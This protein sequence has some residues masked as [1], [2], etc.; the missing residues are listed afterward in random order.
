MR[1]TFILL[2]LANVAVLILFQMSG[3]RTPH[4]ESAAGHEPFQADKVKIVAAPAPV[5]AVATAEPAAPTE[6]LATPPIAP[7][8]ALAPPAPPAK[9]AQQCVEW[10]NLAEADLDRA[11]QALQ[12]LK[13]ADKAN[14]HKSEKTTGYW[15]YV[16][17]R[18]SLAEAQKKVGEL[19]ARGVADIFILQENTAWRY[20]ISLGVF[21]TE[22]AAANYLAQLREKGVRSAVT[23]PRNKAGDAH[24][25]SLRGLD[26]GAAAQIAK[27]A[28][29][30]ADSDV[31][32]VE[33]R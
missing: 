33:C 7:S 19:K 2:L 27:L 21:S 4:A 31:R 22:A 25:V 8:K 26:A 10:N 24:A 1:L 9:P 12:G 14:F 23:G 18:A 5:S 11:R 13:L 17:P 15:V 20:A 32:S 6:I 3:G 28:K 30:F 16:P 29:D